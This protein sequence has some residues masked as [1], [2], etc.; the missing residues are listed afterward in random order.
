MIIC[1]PRLLLL[2]LGA[3]FKDQVHPSNCMQHALVVKKGE[4]EGNS[5]ASLVTRVT[6]SLFPK[7]LR[8]PSHERE[9][10]NQSMVCRIVERNGE[11]SHY[12]RRVF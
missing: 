12:K 4:Q 5:L 9:Q 3:S 8:A 6:T 11:A 10:H 7:G 1:L 2:R